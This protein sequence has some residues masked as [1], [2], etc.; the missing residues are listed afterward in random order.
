MKP[1]PDHYEGMIIDIYTCLDHVN[2]KYW[3][4]RDG[5]IVEVITA[6]P[7]IYLAEFPDKKLEVTD[8]NNWNVR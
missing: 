8:P 6:T 4:R 7:E 2:V 1:I 3:A 5:V